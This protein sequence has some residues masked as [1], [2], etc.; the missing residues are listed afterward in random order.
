MQRILIFVVLLLVVWRV[1]AAIGRRQSERAPGADSFSRFSPE[2]RRRRKSAPETGSRQVEEL[3][4]CSAC[5]TFVPAG[6]ALSDG[7]IRVFCSPGCREQADAGVRDA[8]R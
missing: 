6:R 7:S 4:E 5:G 2:A 8:G 1:L 3:V